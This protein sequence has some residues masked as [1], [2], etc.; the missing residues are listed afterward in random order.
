MA[1][2]S[3]SHA[4]VIGWL[5]NVGS[6]RKGLKGSVSLDEVLSGTT[7]TP[8]SLN[9]F[10]FFLIHQEFSVENLLF[11][12]WFGSYTAR[13]NKLAPYLQSQALPSL[14]ETSFARPPI[15]RNDSMSSMG[16][17][18]LVR[19]PVQK[20]SPLP[21]NLE[22]IDTTTP[23]EALGATVKEE[24]EEQLRGSM[25]VKDQKASWVGGG[26]GGQLSPASSFFPTSDNHF[27]TSQ[28][29][30][31]SLT[32]Q[33]SNLSA[34]ISPFCF[35]TDNPFLPT[36]PSSPT[37]PTGS[38]PP[39][40]TQ[41]NNFRRLQ[42]SFSTASFSRRSS[43]KREDSSTSTST[44]PFFRSGSFAA[45]ESGKRRGENSEEDVVEEMR[46]ECERVW[47]TFFIRGGSKEL[48]L[49]EGVR[50]GV[51]KGLQSGGWHPEVF[52]D[53]ASSCR[54]MLVTHS[55]PNFLNNN[56]GTNIN[57]PKQVF[58]YAVGAIDLFI[59]LLIFL[60]C[61][62]LAPK[63]MGWRCLRF[64]GVVFS[65]FGA[66]Q[67]FSAYLGFCTQVYGR[68]SRQLRPWELDSSSLDV[69][70]SCST[71]PFDWN[72]IVPLSPFSPGSSLGDPFPMSTTTPPSSSAG[73]IFPPSSLDSTKKRL[74]RPPIFGPET[75]I[76]DPQVKELQA[77]MVRDILV[78]GILWAGVGVGVVLGTKGLSG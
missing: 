49:E 5:G 73:L 42:T 67:I 12:T 24:E 8:I 65:S 23:F 37:S 44:T 68:S 38:L 14:C 11:V 59:S 54:T 1:F 3:S 74:D 71:P 35:N 2:A 66:M 16:S 52:A 55:L 7:C 39:P 28:F 45:S 75:I 53:S 63:G 61:I 31:S 21:S 46:Q 32:A 27:S 50:N 26:G 25:D 4:A 69:E 72:T 62:F 30:G 33:S 13:F 47:R 40:P 10:E 15:A 19:T 70:A 51:E 22:G 17:S 56:A 48:N 36:S 60:L 58:W 29:I 43:R 34:L 77:K 78:V 18:V 6:T 9:D 41:Y 20:I 76:M 64:L 57:R